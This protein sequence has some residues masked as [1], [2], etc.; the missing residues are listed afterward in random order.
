VPE[1]SNHSSSGRTNLDNCRRLV[2]A[3]VAELLGAG[4]ENPRLDAEA[5]LAAACHSSRASIV[6]GLA[7]V[8]DWVREGYAGMIERRKRREPLAYILGLKEFYSLVF[9]VTPAVLIP[10][11]ETETLVSTAL[12]FI[13]RHRNPRV[14]DL[15][16]GSGA[17][18]LA[19]ATNAPAAQLIAT[20]ISGEALAIAGHNAA[21]LGLASRV[22]F[23]L[24]DCFEALDRMGPLGRFNLIVSNPPYVPEER[25]AGLAPEITNYEPRAALAGGRDGLELYRRIA[26][27]LTEHLEKGGAAILEI[28]ADQSDAVSQII[29]DAGAIGTTVVE[30]LAGMP[31]VVVAHFR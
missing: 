8:D 19:I 3:G 4:V 1:I 20:D 15:G 30:D 2:S 14:C 10:R 7:K 11:P 23:R 12:E 22:G 6:S 17:I 25:I 26:S 18:A 24:A 16:T 27:K 31:R 5:M 13:Q 29:R 21:R 28:G 9:E